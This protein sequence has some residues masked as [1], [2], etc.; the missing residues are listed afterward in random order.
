MGTAAHYEYINAPLRML[1]VP[2]LSLIRKRH[3]I[4]AITDQIHA[5]LF[6]VPSVHEIY[7][8]N[9]RSQCPSLSRAPSLAHLRRLFSTHEKPVRSW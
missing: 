9:S 2:G 4:I 6:V 3:R 1:A 8:P 7:D 5:Y